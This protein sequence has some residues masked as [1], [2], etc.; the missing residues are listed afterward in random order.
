MLYFYYFFHNAVDFFWNRRYNKPNRR[1]DL[2]YF[3]KEVSMNFHLNR[4][5]LSDFSASIRREWAMANGIGGYAGG[6]VTGACNRTHQGY[7]IA[8]LH[9]PVE[10]FL[11][12]TK[13]N[14]II[15]QNGNTWNLETAQ[16]A[17]PVFTEGQKFL[18]GF[19]YDGTVTFHYEAGDIRLEK[20]IALV[21]GENT[22]VIAYRIHNPG[23]EAALGITPL[24]NYREHSAASTADTLLF[25]EKPNEYNGFTLVPDAAPDVKIVLA[26]SGGTLSGRQKLFDE[27]MQYQ[28]EVDNE[29]DGLDS[30]YTPYDLE[31]SIPADSDMDISIICS[32]LTKG[33]NFSHG[34]PDAQTAQKLIGEKKQYLKQ[35]V[36]NSGYGNDEFAEILVTAADQFTVNPQNRKPC[37]PDSRGSPTGDAIP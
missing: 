5:E 30:H 27:Q 21:Q 3:S 28:T 26:C 19:D 15:M 10:R 37:L 29:V 33:E 11:V 36:K 16:H 13:T 9:P 17:G 23:S 6:S 14:E 8:S 35:L 20:Q 22:A 18:E 4:D 31:F 24:M 25:T 32:V 1:H 34:T 7:L 12:F 2:F